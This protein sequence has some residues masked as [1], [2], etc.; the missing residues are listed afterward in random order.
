MR[1]RLPLKLGPFA[2]MRQEG[3]GMYWTGEH[4]RGAPDMTRVPANARKFRTLAEAYEAANGKRG[5]QSALPVEV[6]A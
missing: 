1:P 2:L 3:G 4:R 6:R 5:L